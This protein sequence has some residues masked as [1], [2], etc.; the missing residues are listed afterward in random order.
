MSVYAYNA[1]TG[2]FGTSQ[3]GYGRVF[4]IMFLALL[5]TAGI[6]IG[7]PLLFAFGPFGLASV[8][9]GMSIFD[10]NAIVFTQTG[11]DIFFGMMIGSAILQ[12]ILTFWITFTLFRNGTESKGLIIPF[13]LYVICMG[14]LISSFTLYIDWYTIGGAFLVTSLA[15]GA[16]AVF[17]M[18]AKG[19]TIGVVGMIGFGLLI[20]ALLISLFG[21]LIYFIAPAS[22]SVFYMVIS[23]VIVIALL[24]VTA[25]EINQMKK[26]AEGGMLTGN[27][28]IYFAFKLYVN[29][30]A[31]FIRL[32]QIIAIARN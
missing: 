3:V 28:A 18:T 23:A 9:E 31:I 11:F 12:L 5:V 6:G 14:V 20:G 25:W 24:L 29:F 8:R 1:H 13:A 7:I 22:Y 32:L 19:K 27:T 10:S 30:I 26:A 16:M 4:G 21:I 2:A 15:F 17:G